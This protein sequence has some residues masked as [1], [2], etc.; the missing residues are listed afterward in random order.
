MP[1]CCLSLYFATY[2]LLLRVITV[3]YSYKFAMTSM[4]SAVLLVAPYLHYGLQRLPELLEQFHWNVGGWKFAIISH[5][6]KILDH[7]HKVSKMDRASVHGALL[8]VQNLTDKTIGFGTMQ[9]IYKNKCVYSHITC[10]CIVPVLLIFVA[11]IIVFYLIVKK[12]FIISIVYC[13]S[14]RLIS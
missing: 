13:S 2:L 5:I 4:T 9:F 1:F 12:Q 8:F 11:N 6:F 7:G 14:L 10:C 3:S